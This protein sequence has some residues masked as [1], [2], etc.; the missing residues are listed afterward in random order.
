[1]I[2]GVATERDANTTTRGG[3]KLLLFCIKEIELS[4]FFP[5]HC[6][7]VHRKQRKLRRG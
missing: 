4:A 7:L 1:M 3:E 6:W 2:G 5:D